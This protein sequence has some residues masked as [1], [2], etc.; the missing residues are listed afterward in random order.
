L[1]GVSRFD[2]KVFTPFAIPEAEPDYTRG[3]TGAKVVHCIM[4]DS[5]GRMWFGTNGGAYIYD[6]NS[7]SNLSEKDG[8][9]DN[10]V[11]CMLEDQDGNIWFATYLINDKK[12][13]SAMLI[14]RQQEIEV[15]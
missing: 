14:I 9:S 8:M 13:N 7:L 11:N 5:K 2:G 10:N 15:L 3:V 4:E 12:Y 1:Q 6:G